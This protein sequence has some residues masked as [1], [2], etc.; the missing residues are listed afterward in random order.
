MHELR[1]RF[2]LR[3]SP[4]MSQAASEVVQV[5]LDALDNILGGWR[6]G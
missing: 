4:F 1:E 2:P 3:S 5:A 6:Y